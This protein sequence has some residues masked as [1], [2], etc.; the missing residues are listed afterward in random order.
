MKISLE[1]FD[2]NYEERD[3]S[4]WEDGSKIILEKEF[5]ITKEI[6]E[7]LEIEE[8][9]YDDN[10]RPIVI[11]AFF[12]RGER[13][14]LLFCGNINLAVGKD[15]SAGREMEIP[16]EKID[17]L[18][19][20]LSPMPAPVPIP[21]KEKIWGEGEVK[22]AISN[23]LS[24]FSDQGVVGSKVMEREKF[25]AELESAVA[26]HD[27]STDCVPG[28]GFISMPSG[29]YGHVSAGVGKRTADQADYVL[30]SEFEY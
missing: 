3:E 26:E 12:A 28:Q 2:C 23:I 29:T 30:V 18:M 17:R 20:I 27:F 13:Y 11:E 25:M 21:E 14:F 5:Q 10:S 22:I 16:G 24:A 7:L 1:D 9:P 6:Q 4:C 19:E 8:V 15:Y